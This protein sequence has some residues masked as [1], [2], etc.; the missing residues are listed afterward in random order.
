MAGSQSIAGHAYRTLEPMAD[1]CQ[2]C[3]IDMFGEDYGDLA[4]LVTEQEAAQGL[5]ANVLCEGCVNAFVDH[6]GRCRARHCLAK[7]GSA[8]PAAKP[9]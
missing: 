7:H 6:A 2:Q 9:S 3:S 8:E 4:G 1:F 5:G